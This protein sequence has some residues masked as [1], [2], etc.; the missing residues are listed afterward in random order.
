MHAASTQCVCALH[1]CAMDHSGFILS[2]T[3]RVCLYDAAMHPRRGIP[4]HMCRGH[5]SFTPKINT[6]RQHQ[7]LAFRAITICLRPSEF[8]GWW[9]WCVNQTEPAHRVCSRNAFPFHES[10]HKTALSWCPLTLSIYLEVLN[11]CN[12][13]YS[14]CIQVWHHHNMDVCTQIQKHFVGCF[15]CTTKQSESICFWREQ[16]HCGEKKWEFENRVSVYGERRE[17]VTF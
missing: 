3:H 17:E 6:M 9:W 2:G 1:L 10:S 8:C 16:G 5:P 13:V 14:M 11:G 7:L 15:V 12:R 4:V